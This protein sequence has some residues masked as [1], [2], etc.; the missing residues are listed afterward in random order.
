MFGLYVFFFYFTIL[1]LDPVVD[2]KWAMVHGGLFRPLFGRGDT[3]VLSHHSICN[4]CI[5]FYPLKNTT[6][7]YILRFNHIFIVF[8]NH[9]RWY[10]S[11]WVFS[12]HPSWPPGLKLP[13]SQDINLPQPVT[14]TSPIK[15]AGDTSAAGRSPEIVP[16]GQ[17]GAAGQ[18]VIPA[19]FVPAYNIRSRPY[20]SECGRIWHE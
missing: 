18:V 12:L 1:Q 11:S 15:S 13:V 6:T 3:V 14:H 7:Y 5:Q 20:I 4:I 19:M 16:A 9:F 10:D 2:F 8:F 17:I